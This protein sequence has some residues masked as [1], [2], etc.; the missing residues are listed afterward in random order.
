MKNATKKS[1]E[2]FFYGLLK[3]FHLEP[4]EVEG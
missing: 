2:A 1:I 4:I 3:A